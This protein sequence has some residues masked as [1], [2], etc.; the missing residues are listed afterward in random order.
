MS[1]AAG[2]RQPPRSGHRLWSF[3]IGR[4][5]GIEIRVH[6]TFFLL[7]A[8]FA[9][10]GSA[11]E[12]PGVAASLA[13][14]ALI[15]SCVVVHEL[16]HCFVG[17]SRGAV[18]HEIVL[19]PIGGVSRLEHLPE[20][21]SDEL[22]M[23]IAGPA[24]SVGLAAL[25]GIAAVLARDAF[26]PIDLFGG[27]FLVGLFWFNLI[28]AAFNLLPA[29]PLDGGRVF[30]ALLERRY[31]LEHATHVAARIGRGVAIALIV[32]GVFF[33]LWLTIIG[34]FVYFGASA[35]EAATIVHVRLSGHRVADAMLLD[36]VIV[37][38]TM[39]VDELRALLRRSAQ[40]AFP[41]VGDAGYEGMVESRAIERSAP[42][43]R[44][45]ELAE[46]EAPA[47]AATD[48]LEDNLPLV[49]SAP[50]RA[51]AV[52]DPTMSVVGV[53]RLED[54]QH[55]VTEDL[56]REHGHDAPSTGAA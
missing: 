30:R 23:A 31:D 55:L 5:S 19:L 52:V 38:P 49:V 44:A 18:V 45:A 14:L 6:Y 47:I 32:G 8:L 35:E 26:L 11:P 43:R 21:P 4:I 53:L 20:T 22:A 54:V 29:F 15:F 24:A 16:A 50:A 1:P 2:T 34:V 13:W 56:L 9:L 39:S 37:D 27:S 17:R 28:I 48:G 12:G 40:R 41:M 10:A 36:P 3:G 25:A 33:D 7:V 46:R 51:L 42:G